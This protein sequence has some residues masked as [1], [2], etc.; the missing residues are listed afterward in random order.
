M[1]MATKSTKYIYQLSDEELKEIMFS[2]Y[3]QIINENIDIGE[4]GYQKFKNGIP[5]I[6]E[7]NNGSTGIKL[8]ISDYYA[9]I[10]LHC[11]YEDISDIHR[12]NMYRAFGKEYLDDLKAE[13]E[14]PVLKQLQAIQKEMADIQSEVVLPE[15]MQ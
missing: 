15:E 11:L 8:E 9:K 6:Y 10:R 4:L 13:L 2:Y 3:K 1:A 7:R 5:I 14:R 12:K